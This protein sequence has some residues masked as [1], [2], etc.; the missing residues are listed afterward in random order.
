VSATVRD[1]TRVSV[2]L[3]AVFAARC[4]A[5]ATL[6]AAGEL[7]LHDAVDKLEHD[8]E[9]DGLV[10]A[11][12][13]DRVQW[14]MTSAFA[15]ARAKPTAWDLGQAFEVIDVEADEQAPRSSRPRIAASTI[16]AMRY[17]AQQ[18]DEQHLRRWLQRFTNEERAALR[19]YMVA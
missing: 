11:L 19:G 13:Q 18:N 16:E 5:R 9:R 10:A 6:Y 17:V 7:T 8:A 14:M 1:M 3:A 15:A 4:K 2:D 12:G